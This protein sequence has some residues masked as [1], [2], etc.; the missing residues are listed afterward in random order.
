MLGAEVMPITVIDRFRVLNK[1]PLKRMTWAVGNVVRERWR[2]LT[3]QLPQKQ[4][5]EKTNQGGSHCFA[6]YPDT[7]ACVIDDVIESMHAQDDAQ[8]L[9]FTDEHFD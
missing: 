9:M 3:G 2:R 1:S 8:M 4:L 7:F 6:I 5:R